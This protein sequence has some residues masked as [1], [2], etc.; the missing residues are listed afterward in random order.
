MQIKTLKTAPNL[1][2]SSDAGIGGNRSGPYI[3]MPAGWSYQWEVTQGITWNIVGRGLRKTEKFQRKS[4]S[5][6]KLCPFK[7][8]CIVNYTFVSQLCIC[9]SI[10]KNKTDEF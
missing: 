2:K 4:R 8:P 3:K 1:A 10:T 6:Q 7:M 9:K 5:K